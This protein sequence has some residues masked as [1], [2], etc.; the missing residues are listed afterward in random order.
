MALIH[1][2]TADFETVTK[3]GT[4]LLDF[5][6][7][8]CGPCKMVA[9]ILDQLAEEYPDKTICKIDVDKEQALAQQ[10]GV[11]SIPTL[12]LMKDGIIID[13]MVGAGSKKKL[14]EFLN[15]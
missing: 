2:T 1:L 7:T 4:V 9:P 3:E 13:K 14:E 10:F 11:M 8:W 15:Q 5:F 12:I 6:A